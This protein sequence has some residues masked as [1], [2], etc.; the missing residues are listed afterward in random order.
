MH[1]RNVNAGFDGNIIDVEQQIFVILDCF[2]CLQFEYLFVKAYATCHIMYDVLNFLYQ[3]KFLFDYHRYN[4]DIITY[5][6]HMTMRVY[7]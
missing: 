7:L 2:Y 3:G 5:V 1:E 4:S 6:I